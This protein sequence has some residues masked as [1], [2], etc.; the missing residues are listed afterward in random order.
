VLD[1]GCGYHAGYLRAMHSR[2]GSGTGI[3]YRV[4]EEVRKLPRLRFVQDSMESAL[5]CVRLAAILGRQ[6][7]CISNI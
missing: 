2:L 4:S 7:R 1:L 3:D 5:H 6:S